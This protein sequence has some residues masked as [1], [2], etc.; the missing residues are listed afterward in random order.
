MVDAA[1][2]LRHVDALGRVNPS[3]ATEHVRHDAADRNRHNG[4]GSEEFGAHDRARK[5]DIGGAGEHRHE[6]DG[7]EE[8]HREVER[9]GERRAQRGTDDEQGGDFPAGERAPSVTAVN[10]ILSANTAKPRC[11]PFSAR[12]TSGSDRP[13]YS[14][15]EDAGE[16]DD[17]RHRR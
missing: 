7:G 13:R 15:P 1:S 10:T 9:P 2:V 16:R 8:R 17:R 11:S 6:T 5:W 12:P 14:L 4:C 3:M